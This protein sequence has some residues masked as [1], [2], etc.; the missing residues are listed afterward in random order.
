MGMLGLALCPN[1]GVASD[2]ELGRLFHNAYSTLL[3]SGL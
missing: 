1:S 2:N 3:G